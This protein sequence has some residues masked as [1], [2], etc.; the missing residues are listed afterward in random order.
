MH[1]LYLLPVYAGYYLNMTV[2]LSSYSRVVWIQK[3]HCCVKNILLLIL[4]LIHSTPTH[5]IYFHTI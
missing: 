3:L 2:S 1:T 4:T 5:P